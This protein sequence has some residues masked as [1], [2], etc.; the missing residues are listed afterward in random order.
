M[1]GAKWGPIEWFLGAQRVHGG[2]VE[3][4]QRVHRGCAE[5]CR[6]VGRY[7]EGPMEWLLGA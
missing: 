5:G 2:H 4:I 1:E 7:T 6:M 3:G